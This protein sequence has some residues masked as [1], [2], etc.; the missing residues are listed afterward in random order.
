MSIYALVFNTLV[1]GL[2]TNIVNVLALTLQR[3][4]QLR[5][6]RWALNVRAQDGPGGHGTLGL[7][8][9]LSQNG[10]RSFISMARTSERTL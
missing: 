1:N 9:L 6:G 8:F 10:P 3:K 2:A 4:R 7:S 5:T